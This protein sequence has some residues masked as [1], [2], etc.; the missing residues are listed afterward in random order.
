MTST[1]LLCIVALALAVF[2]IAAAADGDYDD[3]HRDNKGPCK[4]G[5]W[6]DGKGCCP[7]IIQ[8][9]AYYRDGN[10][11]Y[12]KDVGCGVFYADGNGYYPDEKGHYAKDGEDC[13]DERKCHQYCIRPEHDDECHERST[14]RKHHRTSTT[15][16]CPKETTTTERRTTPKRTTTT[17]ECPKETTSTRKH[18]TTSTT[19]ECPK[20]TTSTK[21]HRTTSTTEGC[22]KETTSTKKHYSTTSEKCDDKK[23]Q[24]HGGQWSDDDGC[25]PRKIGH[26]WYY[27]DAHGCYPVERECGGVYYADGKGC[28]PDANGEY[29][30]Y[31]EKCPRHRQ[32]KRE[33]DGN[34]KYRD[35]DDY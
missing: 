27:R 10:K 33:C 11:C 34:K 28:Y 35:G 25:C 15:E 29:L 21:K 23:K 1:K 14:T 26:Q 22:P 9:K 5:Y 7:K 20:E 32:C 30:E 13:D 17:E 24:C 8:G 19:E 2:A 3:K 6:P 16:E 31:G 18:H 4:G 12:P